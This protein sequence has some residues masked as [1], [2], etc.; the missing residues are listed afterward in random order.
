MATSNSSHNWPPTGSGS[1]SWKDAV[2]TF[3]SLPPG[4]SVGEVRLTVDTRNLYE[5]NGSAW[6]L[7]L[8]AGSTIT[9]P[10]SSTDNAVARWDGTTGLVIQNSLVTIGDTGNIAGVV[11]FTAT[12]T[13]TLAV[14]LTGVALLTSGVV[15][16]SVTTATELSYVSGVTSAIQTQ[17]NGK[18]AS[19]SYITALTGDVT[20]TGPGSVAATI[21]NLAVTNAKI[22]NATID[23]TTKVTGILPTANGGTGQN[24]TATFPTSGVV[25]TEAASEVLTNKTI[26]GASNTITNISLTTGVTG[27]LPVANGGTGVTSS[28]GSGSN[29]LNTSPTLVTPLLGT[30]TSGVMTNVTGLPLTSGVTGILPVGNGGTG[31]GTTFTD[32][33]VIFA[34]ASGIHSQDNANFFWDRTNIRLGLGIATPVGTLNINAAPTAAATSAVLNITNGTTFSGG[35]AAGQFFGI[36]APSG[37]TANLMTLCTNGTIVYEARSTGSFAF[38]PNT[39]GSSTASAIISSSLVSFFPGIVGSGSIKVSIAPSSVQHSSGIAT[40]LNMAIV[41]ATTS[42]AGYT[43]ILINKTGSGTGSG[44]KFLIDLQVAAASKLTVT[45][46]GLVGIGNNA[47]AASSVLDLTSTTG[48]LLHPRMTTTQRDALTAVDGMMLYNSTTTQVEARQNGAWVGFT[49]GTATLAATTTVNIASNVTLTDKAV[50]FVSTAAARSLTLPAPATTRFIVIKD[51]TGSCATNNITLLRAASEK[52]ETV[53]ASFVLDTDLGSW[54]I[55]SDGTDY[56]II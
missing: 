51:S 7:I 15:S 54:T 19:G 40:L 26:S 33:S 1:P 56:F 43:G 14:A 29:V 25:V 45:S 30:P 21:A 9:G 27:T 48:A 28:T 36:N 34:A 2:A 6:I 11:D 39:A 20:A 46:T 18:Q 5:W 38:N 22:A 24:S 44:A 16:A 8:A 23:L 49:T 13:T 3:A 47:P 4:G 55:V 50:H 10:G 32:G 53:A 52:I 35:A 17:L 12:G 41:D 42:T 37:N 31:T